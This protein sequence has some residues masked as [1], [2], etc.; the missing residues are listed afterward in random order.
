METYAW[1]QPYLTSNPKIL[2]VYGSLLAF[3][4]D[5]VVKLYRAEIEVDRDALIGQIVDN[6]K[7]TLPRFT[8]RVEEALDAAFS[9]SQDLYSELGVVDSLEEA[10]LL[11][12]EIEMHYIS[13]LSS[14]LREYAKRLARSLEEDE[15]EALLG[16]IRA[17]ERREVVR[18]LTASGS[19]LVYMPGLNIES[20][21]LAGLDPGQLEDIFASIV[22]VKVY[23]EAAIPAYFLSND[24]KSLL[25]SKG[26]EVR[27]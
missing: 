8:G 9:F 12:E 6:L 15:V 14:P 7:L 17:I 20:T 11:I 22:L 1:V 18:D 25:Q 10:K 4:M 26:L 23:D 24:F 16:V 19:A 3:R 2:G 13:D 21:T 27:V 5:Y